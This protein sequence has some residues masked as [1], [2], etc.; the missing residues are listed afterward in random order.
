MIRDLDDNIL[1][2]LKTV[3]RRLFLKQ[4]VIA[5]AVGL[6]IGLSLWLGIV[7]LSQF[8]PIYRVYEKGAITAIIITILS[9]IASLLKYPDTKKAARVC[10]AGGLK[11]RVTTAIELQG[12]ED[13]LSLLV[14]KDALDKLKRV[15]HKRIIK[16]AMP[17]RYLYVISLLAIAIFFT[18]FLPHP[19]KETARL[20]HELKV[21]KNEQLQKLEEVS[22]DISKDLEDLAA[23]GEITPE[24]KA[25]AEKILQDLKKNISE[26]KSSEEIS[27]AVNRGIAKIENL[28]KSGDSLEAAA[29]ELSKNPAAKELSK[30]ISEGNGKNIESEISNL[31]EKMKSMNEGDKAALEASLKAVE[32]ALA[33]QKANESL[34]L[35]QK[36]LA[37]SMGGSSGQLASGNQGGK[38]EGQGN[39]EGQQGGGQQGGG[40]Q[41]GGAG[42]G[43]G[44][45]P[46]G[47]GSGG[48]SGGLVSKDPSQGKERAYEKIYTPKNLGG[49][50]T[51]SEL[52][53]NANEGSSGE[54]IKGQDNNVMKGEYKPY[55]QVLGQYKDRAY[56]SMSS[57]DLPE[58]MQELIKMYFS[59]LEE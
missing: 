58:G 47:S 14:K 4:S 31:K 12:K 53:G 6:C 59:S 7:V 45:D 19:L 16:V 52:I 41:G 44:M 32:K 8:T 24:K 23:T 34:A 20:N 54:I 3:K 27:K 35:V 38:E 49:E 29:S 48:S 25:E 17:E 2:Q 9:L 11:E 10:D 13:T 46:K 21:L 1:H 55:N 39:S 30:A 15:N 18:V 57:Y 43:E 5:C 22:K 56:Q 50:G 37:E 51:V 36:K 42:S 40:Q 28:K 26:S 33:E